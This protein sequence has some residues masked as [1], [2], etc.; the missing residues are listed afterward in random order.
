VR[1][2]VRIDTDHHIRHAQASFTATETDSFRGG[3]V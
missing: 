3:H 2:L 1:S